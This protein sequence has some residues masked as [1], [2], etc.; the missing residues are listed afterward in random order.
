MVY[1]V[2]CSQFSPNLAASNVSKNS[3]FMCL[4]LFFP[5]LFL[6]PPEY[7]LRFSGILRA[8]RNV[9][10]GKRWVNLFMPPMSF[11]NLHPPP[12]PPSKKKQTKKPSGFLII[13]GVIERDQWHEI[14]CIQ[15]LLMRFWC[16]KIINLVH[17]QSFPKK[18]TFSNH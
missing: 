10:L 14:D 7:N 16:P 1:N 11:Y 2:F 6:Y 13:S 3:K 15:T 8:N 18:L 12:H 5:V 4:I 17:K 9:I